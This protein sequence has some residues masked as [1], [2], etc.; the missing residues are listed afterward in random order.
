MDYD[1]LVSSIKP[2]LDAMKGILIQDDSPDSVD[3]HVD[4]RKVAHK[5]DERVEFE[6][7]YS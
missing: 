7:H 3:L 4:G 5:D 1:N 6:I 2:V